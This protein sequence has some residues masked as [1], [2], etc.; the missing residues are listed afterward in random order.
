M[1]GRHCITI[2][3]NLATRLAASLWAVEQLAAVHQ[4]VDLAPLEAQPL[5]SLRDGRELAG[6]DL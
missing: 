6:D 5:S 2:A 3:P 1:P 4:A